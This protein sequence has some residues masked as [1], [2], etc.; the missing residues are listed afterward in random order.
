MPLSIW[1]VYLGL[2]IE[3][4]PDIVGWYTDAERLEPKILT[5]VEHDKQYRADA[6]LTRRWIA[7]ARHLQAEARRLTLR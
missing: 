5:I 6:E 7:K 3:L 4:V 1:Q 2:N